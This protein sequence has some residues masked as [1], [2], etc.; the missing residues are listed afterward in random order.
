ML[1]TV[2]GIYVLLKLLT[3]LLPLPKLR[4]Y[5][6][7]LRTACCMAGYIKNNKSHLFPGVLAPLASCTHVFPHF[8]LPLFVPHDPQLTAT[9]GSNPAL[10]NSAVRLGLE[11]TY[12]LVTQAIWCNYLINRVWYSLYS[13]HSWSQCLTDGVNLHSTRNVHT[14]ICERY[15]VDVQRGVLYFLSY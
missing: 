12:Q 10:L 1:L 4:L 9:F 5:S 14:F 15:L 7:P 8:P 11:V 13:R 6:H 2:L 3:W